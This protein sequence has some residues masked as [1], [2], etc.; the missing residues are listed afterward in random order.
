MSL[1]VCLYK[2]CDCANIFIKLQCYVSATDTSVFDDITEILLLLPA[3]EIEEQRIAADN[4]RCSWRHY[5]MNFLLTRHTKLS[6]NWCFG[7]IKRTFR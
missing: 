1:F 2:L 6:F 4:F 3:L 5:T 7:L